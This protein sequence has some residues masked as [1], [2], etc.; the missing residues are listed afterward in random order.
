MEPPAAEV[1]V[2]L[3]STSAATDLGYRALHDL[4]TAA[5]GLDF[6]IIG[7][8]MV[9]LLIHAYP[10]ERAQLR[11]TTDAD[12]G[13]D[14][15]TAIG[16]QLHKNLTQ[17]GYTP[18]SGNRYEKQHISGTM[19]VDVLIPRADSG[20]TEVLGER[21]YDPIPGLSL[22][23]SAQYLLVHAT[24][25]LADGTRLAFSV[26]VPDIEAAVILKALAWAAR[27]APKDIAD[28]ASLLEIV[29]RHR[30][31]HPRWR[32]DAR[33]LTSSSRRDAAHALHGIAKHL[34][35]GN[36]PELFDNPARV[37]ALIRRHITE[38]E[39]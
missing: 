24:A 29:E 16:Q 25:H 22:A 21:G 27:I 17:I 15:A 11:L 9:Q 7:G 30:P 13:I 39:P 8:H 4:A 35:R 14:R 20:A 28:L 10:T 26:P 12:I 32:L 18:G 6:R 23:M 5:A 2:E 33:P 37:V 38:P 3:I 1:R 31:E 36:S 19:T 34:E